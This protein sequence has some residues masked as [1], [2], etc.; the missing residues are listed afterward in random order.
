MKKIKHRAPIIFTTDSEGRCL[1]HV[2]LAETNQR[3]TLY[4]EDLERI[5]AEGWSPF[6]SY[7]STNKTAP[8]RKYVLVHAIGANGRRRSLTVA[9][10]IAKASKGQRVKYAD[11]DRLNLCP[12]NLLV[13][14]GGAWMPLESLRPRMGAQREAAVTTGAPPD[15]IG[16]RI[17]AANFREGI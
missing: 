10:L 8:H 14:K 9:R 12:E 6:W 4:A 3:T 2:A 16:P 1:A 11:G 17:P 5:L 13:K 7:T 15:S